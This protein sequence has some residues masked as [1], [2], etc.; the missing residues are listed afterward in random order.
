MK[1]P[2]PN[3]EEEM[4]NC[5]YHSGIVADIANLKKSDDEQW[6]AIKALQNR[7][8]IW[9]T[10]VISILTFSL[11]A[12]LTYASLAIKMTEVSKGISFLIQ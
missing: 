12:T 7:L 1:T 2:H 8:P 3:N 11:G 6:D 9:A 4:G 10:L 5:T